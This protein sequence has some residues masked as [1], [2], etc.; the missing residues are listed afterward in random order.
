MII[1][2]GPL[3]VTVHLDLFAE[4]N[5][6]GP[7]VLHQEMELTSPGPLDIFKVAEDSAVTVKSARIRKA[8]GGLVV[9][10]YRRSSDAEPAVAISFAIDIHEDV[11]LEALDRNY[12]KDNVHVFVKDAA[13]S[14]MKFER[15]D[16]SKPEP[17]FFV[18]REMV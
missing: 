2:A 7:A 8:E 17:Q 10:L 1:P 15:V 12:T 13:N 6:E 18:L 4:R 5:A 14:D 16:I 9:G 3:D 11:L